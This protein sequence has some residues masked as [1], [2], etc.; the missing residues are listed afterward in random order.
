[1]AFQRHLAEQPQLGFWLQYRDHLH[2]RIHQTQDQ[3]MA[4][5]RHTWRVSASGIGTFK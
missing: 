4:N 5:P 1:M 3:I 2:T